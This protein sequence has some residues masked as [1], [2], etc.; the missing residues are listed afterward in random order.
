MVLM[1]FFCVMIM[2][3]RHSL[4]FHL[5]FYYPSAGYSVDVCGAGASSELNVRSESQGSLYASQAARNYLRFPATASA[6][7]DWFLVWVY[8]WVH[9]QAESVSTKAVCWGDVFNSSVYHNA[10]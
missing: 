9:A 1:L 2:L 8:A 5:D 10:T 4:V 6:C 7:A 3:L